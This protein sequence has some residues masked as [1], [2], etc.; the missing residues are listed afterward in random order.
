MKIA[1]LILGVALGVIVSLS[2]HSCISGEATAWVNSV[3][4]DDELSY[5]EN[6]V[7]MWPSG[8]TTIEM[9]CELMHCKEYEQLI[10]E[11]NESR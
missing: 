3:E 10:R 2:V 4:D 5:N 1:E 6:F 11:T 9:D 8:N 7:V